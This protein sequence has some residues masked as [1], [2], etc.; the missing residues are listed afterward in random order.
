MNIRKDYSHQHDTKQKHE[1]T[2]Y[3]MSHTFQETRMIISSTVQF[4]S[5]QDLT[6]P[7]FKHNNL[8]TC[9]PTH[10]IPIKH[11]R[12]VVSK[13]TMIDRAYG[14]ESWIGMGRRNK[15]VGSLPLEGMATEFLHRHH[16]EVPHLIFW[17]YLRVCRRPKPS[18][19]CSIPSFII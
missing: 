11:V 18:V 7:I 1:T 12:G 17:V 19:A 2:I 3:A 13:T 16:V 5:T 6:T 4:Q 10:K 9:R 15:T 8:A 14:F